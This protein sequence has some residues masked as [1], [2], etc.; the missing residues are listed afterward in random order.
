MASELIAGYTGKTGRKSSISTTAVQMTTTD[1]S[2]RRGVVI[3]AA[4]ANTGKVYVGFSSSITND[5]ADATD[6]IELGAGQSITL[7]ID[8]ANKIYVIGSA[9]SQKVFWAAI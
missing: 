9:A 5:S 6:G 2:C 7:E 1:F 4:D 3:K 8:N